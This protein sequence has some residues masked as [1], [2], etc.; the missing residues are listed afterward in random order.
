MNVQQ[1][2]ICYI[3]LMSISSALNDVQSINV[4]IANISSANTATL[5]LWFN[6]TIY[7]YILSA[8][9]SD[10]V[11]RSTISAYKDTNPTFTILGSS[12]CHPTKYHN[13]PEAKVLVEN[14]DTNQLMINK[15]WF[16]LNDNTS[17]GWENIC[18]PGDGINHFMHRNKYQLP[19]NNCAAS[20]SNYKYLCIDHEPDDCGP[21]KQIIYFDL[22][23]PNQNISNAKWADGT[24][25]IPD[26]KPCDPI[27]V[28]WR[29]IYYDYLGSNDANWT[30]HNQ[31]TF[32]VASKYPY[33]IN[34]SCVE[35]NGCSDPKGGESYIE[36]SF[37]ISTGY[38]SIRLQLDITVY[39]IEEWNGDYCEIWYRYDQHPFVLITQLNDHI[40]YY[41]DYI[42]LLEPPLPMYSSLSIRLKANGGSVNCQ[43]HCYWNN[44]YIQGIL[45]N[46]TQN[47][48]FNSTEILSYIVM[49]ILFL[50]MVVVMILWIKLRKSKK[51]IHEN[52]VIREQFE[53]VRDA[54]NQIKSAHNEHKLD[55]TSTMSV[56]SQSD[57]TI[58][59]D[60]Y[61]HI[62]SQVQNIEIIEESE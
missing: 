12:T 24:N 42:V 8:I 38:T 17:F 3:S 2:I 58:S 60:K 28:Q 62:S 11:L 59:T 25:I 55:I 4:E 7:Q 40:G 27:S 19:H 47:T 26:I 36:N 23:R 35:T 56:M 13:K 53:I 43:D 31:V 49:V 39:D 30:V 33:L 18:I 9:S 15:I 45:A 34:E 14:N 21:Y 48:I 51:E 16:T 37:D 54:L 1:I 41:L 57:N 22:S 44:L 6:F 46:L 10:S 32:G 29:D 50:C 61:T 20:H 5:T 52:K